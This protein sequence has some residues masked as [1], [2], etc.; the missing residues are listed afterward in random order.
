M[1]KMS[2]N[3]RKASINIII[4]ETLLIYELQ[5][6]EKNEKFLVDYINK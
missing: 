2:Q 6:A 3:Y 5:G 1:Y 4:I